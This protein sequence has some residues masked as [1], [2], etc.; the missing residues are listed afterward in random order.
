M[1]AFRQLV[2]RHQR[3]AFA[4]ALALVRDENDARE[5]VQDAF[6]RAFQ[7]PA[8]ASRAARASSPGSTGS[9]RTSASTSCA[10]P[11]GRPPTSTRPASPAD[12]AADVDFPMLGRFDGADPAD[13]VRRDG[14]RGASPGRARRSA[15]LPPGGHRDA[16]GRGPELRGDGAGHGRLEGHDHEPPLPRPSE[17]P[18]GARRLLRGAGRRAREARPASEERAKP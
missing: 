10:S 16:R 2:E 8:D 4:I 3:R 1:G 9:S 13:V 18:A 15:E 5:I 14:D 17:A 6:L 7:E 11:A 12:D